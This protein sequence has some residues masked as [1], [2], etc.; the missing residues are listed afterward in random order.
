[1]IKKRRES[2]FTLIELMVV[3]VIVGI[4][5][6]MGLGYYSTYVL[7]GK[8]NTVKPY[9]SQI[10]AKERGHLLR[11]G[12]YL[13]SNDEQ[14]LVNNLGVSLREVGDFCFMVLSAPGQGVIST[15]QDGDNAPEF[16]VW[17]VLRNA[18]ADTVTVN[19]DDRVCTVTR[20]ASQARTKFNATGWVRT[21][22]VGGRGSE[23]RVVV[24][25]YPPPPDR[26]DNAAS[27]VSA[28]ARHNWN[29]GVSLSDAM[30]R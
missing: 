23:G 27:T 16:E 13:F 17:A 20:D 29:Q 30:A 15:R 22:A 8:L 18:A 21:A 2:G 19:G 14:V 11:Q 7:E 24:L 3:V 5:A 12:A 4:L 1:M 25:R 9:L 26:L 28:G 6:S 10:A